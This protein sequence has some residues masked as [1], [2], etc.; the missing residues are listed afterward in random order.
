V[1]SGGATGIDSAA[2]EGALAA[3][4]RTLAW[5]GSAI[6]RPYPR[7]ND[8]LFARI[9]R[10]GGALASEH[11]PLART[12][13]SDHAARNRLIVGR[14]QALCV[15]EAG[16]NSGTMGAARH[17][18]RRGVPLFVPPATVGGERAGIDALCA[19]GAAAVLSDAR[20]PL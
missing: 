4:G 19:Q 15:A 17:A 1:I 11:P 3:G 12:F 9:L 8:A 6:D 16:A 13:A 20:R 5:L 10:H 7:A 2:H 14:A 18:R